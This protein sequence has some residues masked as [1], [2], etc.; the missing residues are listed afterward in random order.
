MKNHGIAQ[1][2]TVDKAEGVGVFPDIKQQ[3]SATAS[4]FL[5][6]LTPAQRELRNE[7]RA[8]CA[9]CDQASGLTILTVRC[10]ACGCGAVS[11]VHGRCKLRR[12]T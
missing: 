9:D 12:W 6:L 4:H 3:P 11:L 5:D 1:A 2:T 8:I 7:R 10:G